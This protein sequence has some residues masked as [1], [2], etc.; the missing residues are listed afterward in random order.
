M[1]TDAKTNFLYLSDKLQTEYKDFWAHFEPLLLQ[2]NIRYDTL[3]GTNDV[4]CRDFMPVQTHQNRFVQ[5]V[6]DPS[7]LDED[8]YRHT[9]TDPE[10]ITKV[11]GIEPVKT[12]I[13]L[14]GGN[15]VRCGNKVI[16]T[17]I[18]YK[19]NPQYDKKQLCEDIRELLQ[20]EHLFVIPKQP[21]DFTGHADGMVRFANEHTLLVNDFRTESDTFN[22]RLNA[23]LKQ[24]GL[25]LE[26]YVYKPDLSYSKDSAVGTYINFLHIGNTI[27][28][29][30]FNKPEDDIALKQTE[31]LY[32]NCT[33]VPVI[34][35][36]IAQE[37]G[38]L[39]CISWNIQQ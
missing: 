34:S 29:P 30:F 14:D 13:K 6:Y 11:L 4:W 8:E 24:T 33:I 2:H 7:Y 15:M 23:A 38:V 5:F 9:I 28:L 3:K 36:Q 18:I 16:V 10:P 32:P 27:F 1:T 25:K 12:G 35:T 19:E 26:T 21:G 22:K 17:D 37:S 20:T 31:K 39:N